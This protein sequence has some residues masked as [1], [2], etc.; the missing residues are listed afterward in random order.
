MKARTYVMCFISAIVAL[1]I[2]VTPLP[3]LLNPM[4]YMDDEYPYWIQQKNYIYSQHPQKRILLLGDSRMKMDVI[5]NDMGKDVYNLALGGGTSIEMYYTMLHYLEHNDAPDTVIIGFGPT[6]YVEIGTYES[7]NLYFHYL[8]NSEIDEVDK[9]MKQYDGKDINA[10]P[11]KYRLPSVYLKPLIKSIVWPRLQ[12]NQ[13]EYNRVDDASGTWLPVAAKNMDK[14]VPQEV[15]QKKFI[16]KKSVDY[17]LGKLIE[18]CKENSIEVF[19]EQLPMGE[20]GH[21]KLTQMGYLA[22]YYVYMESLKE[23]YGIT[24]NE[25]LPVYENKYFRDGSHLNENG[26]TVFTEELKQ[27]YSSLLK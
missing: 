21:E 18:L 25:Q 17:Y 7:R 13:E 19:I 16:V 27:K 8:E 5:A 2:V 3:W 1:V 4:K 6:H 26:A 11:Y 23:K 15:G 12:K 20:Y 22:D 9:I 10:T 14:V 24:V